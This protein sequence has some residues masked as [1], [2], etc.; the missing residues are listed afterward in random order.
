MIH[1]GGAEIARVDLHVLLPIE[2][3]AAKSQPQEV[4][5]ADALTRGHHIVIG[6]VL[7]EHA[8]H[9]LH[10]VAREAPVAFGVQVAEEELLLQPQLDA[11][12]GP[13]DL[14]GNKGLAAARA[15]VIEQDAVA[16]KE[17]VA[18]PVVDHLVVG[19]DLGAG[20]GAAGLEARAFMLAGL[21]ASE[22]L[23][24]AGLVKADL[25]ATVLHEA[26]DGL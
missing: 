12:C 4:A 24:A 14:A 25:L 19:I 11:G 22:H 17:T 9:G 8:P 21:G 20:I 7:L 16:G 26:S 15:L 1:F 10:I 5:D 3:Q 13:G 6:L 18:F 2:I 23:G